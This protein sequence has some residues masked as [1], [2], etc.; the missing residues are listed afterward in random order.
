MEF[1]MV[2]ATIVRVHRPLSAIAGNRLPGN[3]TGRKR[4]TFGQ[5]IGKSRRGMTTKI[6]ALTDA[7]GNILSGLPVLDCTQSKSGNLTKIE[8]NPLWATL[9]ASTFCPDN[10]M[11]PSA[12]PL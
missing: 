10:V 5:A 8:C 11:T 2:D 12:W 7:I 4:G 6:L 9:S 3:G 1:A